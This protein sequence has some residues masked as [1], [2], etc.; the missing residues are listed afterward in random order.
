MPRLGGARGE[1]LRQAYATQKFFDQLSSCT[2]SE[3]C[4]HTTGSDALAHAKSTRAHINPTQLETLLETL[5]P[6]EVE[7][8]KASVVRVEL[9]TKPSFA[10]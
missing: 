7:S 2:C 8:F 10:T 9:L 6:Q 5:S 1:A 3:P 4:T